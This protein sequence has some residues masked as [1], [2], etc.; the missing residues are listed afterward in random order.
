MIKKE[1]GT[2][3]DF[4]KNEDKEKEKNEKSRRIL[5]TVRCPSYGLVTNPDPDLL[6]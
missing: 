4:R 5:Q 3:N 1:G 2:L 6:L